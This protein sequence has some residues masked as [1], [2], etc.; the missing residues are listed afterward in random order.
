MPRCG[1]IR[2]K[3]VDVIARLVQLR[4]HAVDTSIATLGLVRISLQ[5][6]FSYVWNNMLHTSVESLIYSILSSPSLDLKLE[7]LQE[8][9]FLDRLVEAT[10][11]HESKIQSSGKGAGYMGHIYRICNRM[12]DQLQVDSILAGLVAPEWNNFYSTKVSPINAVYVSEMGGAAPRRQPPVNVDDERAAMWASV[13]TLLQTLKVYDPNIAS[14]RAG[15][16]G[17]EDDEGMSW[18]EFTNGAM[19]GT[20]VEEEEGDEFY[21][22]NV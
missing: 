8:S 3:I 2:I 14:L 15:G 19:D 6:F 7:V 13:S 11:E 4:F 18:D 22:E 16:G 1:I 12:Q 9:K 5:L 10:A 21:N 20:V 17:G